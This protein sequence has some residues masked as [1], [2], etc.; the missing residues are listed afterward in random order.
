VT[1]VGGHFDEVN[2]TLLCGLMN[3]SDEFKEHYSHLFQGASRMPSTCIDL[4]ITGQSIKEI[5]AAVPCMNIRLSNR[6]RDGSIVHPE[7]SGP[8]V[9]LTSLRNEQINFHGDRLLI[10]QRW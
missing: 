10:P 2:T 7:I 3:W 9:M 5:M 4:Q 1:S 6:F 8:L